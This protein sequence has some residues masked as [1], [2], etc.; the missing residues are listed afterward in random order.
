MSASLFNKKKFK[1]M[2]KYNADIWGLSSQRSLRNPKLWYETYP[3][4]KQVYNFLNSKN[5]KISAKDQ[6]FYTAMRHHFSRS[7]FAFFFRKQQQKTGILAL[8]QLPPQ[9]NKYKRT[10]KFQHFEFNQQRLIRLFYNNI[11]HKQLFKLYKKA[12]LKKYPYR[13][14]D[15]V[16]GLLESRLDMILYRALFC[17]SVSEAR[18]L[19]KHGY[20]CVNGLKI[21]HTNYNLKIGD[22]ISVNLKYK[23]KF[24]IK[25]LNNIKN[26]KNITRHTPK[27]IEIDF[28][29]LSLIKLAEP[30]QNNVFYPFKFDKKHIFGLFN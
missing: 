24:F 19:I 3:L 12:F 17:I 11:K 7:S 21:N 28:K 26:K 29:N 8:T 22:I 23:Q 9:K 16:Y 14:I 15:L 10:T 13:S 6:Q 2:K 30:D 27:Y 5:I 1:R 4:K 20:F 25:I 18:Q